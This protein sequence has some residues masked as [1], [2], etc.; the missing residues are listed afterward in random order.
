MSAKVN[1]DIK[2]CGSTETTLN[3]MLKYISANKDEF[4]TIEATTTYIL[5]TRKK[6][7]ISTFGI[8]YKY[9][10]QKLPKTCVYCG[11]KVTYE[12]DPDISRIISEAENEP[13]P[14]PII[15]DYT[16]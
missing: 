12:Y 4:Q 13:L 1:I 16:N 14:P 7:L 11:A 5:E 9:K 10:P 2:K 8:F 6:R 3:Y 15:Q